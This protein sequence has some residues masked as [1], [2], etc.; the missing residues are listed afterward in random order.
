VLWSCGRFGQAHAHYRAALRIA[1]SVAYRYGESDAHNNLALV[2]IS[3][4]AYGAALAHAEAALSIYRASGNRAGE[5]LGL[6]SLGMARMYRS[7]DSAAQDAFVTSEYI[8]M[9]TGDRQNES[10]A[11]LLSAMLLMRLGAYDAARAALDRGLAISRKIDHRWGLGVGLAYEGMLRHL[12]GDQPGAVASCRAALEISEQMG[13]LMIGAYALTHLGHALAAMG[14]LSEAASCYERTVSIRDGLCQQHL[15]PDARAGLA[16]IALERGDYPVARA[17]CE[18]ILRTA[19]LT[20][21]AGVEEPT[22]VILT[23]YRGLTLAGDAR[24][25]PLLDNAGQ[26]L[27]ERVA[28]LP[29]PWLQKTLGNA[30]AANRELLALAD[31]RGKEIGR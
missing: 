27:R 22:R 6:I 13:D 25:E 26:Q 16:R 18:A 21:L 10:F 15:T 28:R 8:F 5:G 9:L 20:L 23:C 19:E 29:N 2:A 30:V 12:T 31:Q 11:A 4:G 24:A 1:Q 14:Q 7:E 17:H 3:Q